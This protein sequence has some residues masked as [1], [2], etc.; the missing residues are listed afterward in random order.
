M[1]DGSEIFPPN[2]SKLPPNFLLENKNIHKNR[3]KN[4]N[5]QEKRSW[6]SESA[7]GF[8]KTLKC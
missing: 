7:K 1:V 4:K 6:D 5:I 2:C 3:S 8:A